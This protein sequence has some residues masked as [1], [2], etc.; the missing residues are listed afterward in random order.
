M[1]RI[2]W[3]EKSKERSVERFVPAFFFKFIYTNLL[4]IYITHTNKAN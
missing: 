3:G 4:L 1:R 2:I